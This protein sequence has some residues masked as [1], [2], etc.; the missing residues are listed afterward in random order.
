MLIFFFLMRRRPARSTRTDTLFPYTTLFRSIGDLDAGTAPGRLDDIG[1]GEPR[2]DID[3]VI[4]GG[5]GRH[6]LRLGLHDVGQ[7]GVARLVEAQI[8]GDD[9]RQLEIIGLEPALDFA[10]PL[11]MAVRSVERRVGTARVRTCRPRW[12]PYP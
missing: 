7:R 6:R 12:S 1:D 11:G 2:C 8:G 9:R 5:L 4:G 3:A 10:R